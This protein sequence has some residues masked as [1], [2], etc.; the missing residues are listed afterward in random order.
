MSHS[1]WWWSWLLM[2]VGVTGLY[3]SGKQKWWGWL[4][5]LLSEIL[6]MIYAVVTEQYGFIVFALVYAIVFIKNAYSWY[7][8][9]LKREV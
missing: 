1:A 7:N 4:I 2:I 3:F 8:N 5:G 6:W 9:S